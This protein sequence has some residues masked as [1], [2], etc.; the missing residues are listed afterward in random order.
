[1]FNKDPKHIT[2]DKLKIITIQGGFIYIPD[3]SNSSSFTFRSTI[4]LLALEATKEISEPA[5]QMALELINNHLI[6]EQQKR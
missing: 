3:S 6:S 1:M 5:T 4:L 2:H